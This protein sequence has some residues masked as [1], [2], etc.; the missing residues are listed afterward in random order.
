ME[1]SLT[2]PALLYQNEEGLGAADQDMVFGSDQEVAPSHTGFVPEEGS[3]LMGSSDS[4]NNRW[5]YSCPLF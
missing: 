2:E 1:G 5:P 3:L 4:D